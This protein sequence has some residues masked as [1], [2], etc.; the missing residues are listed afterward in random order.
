[1]TVAEKALADS[2]TAIEAARK[3]VADAEVGNPYNWPLTVVPK[4]VMIT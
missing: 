4:P 1:M 2:K 3:K